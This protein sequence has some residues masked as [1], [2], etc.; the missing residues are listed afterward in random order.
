MW[1]S[2]GT[3]VVT[4]LYLRT[5]ENKRENRMNVEKIRSL[6]VVDERILRYEEEKVFH[7]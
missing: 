3:S 5:G 7:F 1:S 2:D 4:G 6:T